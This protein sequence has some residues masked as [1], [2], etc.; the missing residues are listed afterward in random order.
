MPLETILRVYR[1]QNWYALSDRIAV[2]MFRDSERH[3][4][5]QINPRR[6]G[7]PDPFAS[8]ASASPFPPD[9]SRFVRNERLSS[10]MVATAAIA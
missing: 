8:T 1:L 2:E 3:L 4:A 5:M 9:W 6:P 10:G 7:Q